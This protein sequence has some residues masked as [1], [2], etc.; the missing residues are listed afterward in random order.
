[1]RESTGADLWDQGDIASIWL[2]RCDSAIASFCAGR[3]ILTLGPWSRI[4]K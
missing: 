4:V 3:G 1:M 2:A